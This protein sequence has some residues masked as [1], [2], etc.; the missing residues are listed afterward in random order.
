MFF[1]S[2]IRSTRTIACRPPSWSRS[3]AARE[4][5]SSRAARLRSSVAVD[6]E[7]VHAQD[8]VAPLVP[9]DAAADVRVQDLGAAAPR[10]RLP[11]GG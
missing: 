11:I 1:D 6:A 4:T 2:S 3:V 5:T 9:D 10:T 8:G 7:R